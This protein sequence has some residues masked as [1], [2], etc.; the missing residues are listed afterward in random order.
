ME[1][2]LCVLLLLRPTF[3]PDAANFVAADMSHQTNTVVASIADGDED[4]EID[5][6]VVAILDWYHIIF[7][8][9]HFLRC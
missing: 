1:G 9:I 3:T 7:S 2:N 4:H 6:V 8:F 5:I